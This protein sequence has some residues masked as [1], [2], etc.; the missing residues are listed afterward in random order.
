MLNL[1]KISFILQL[2]LIVSNQALAQKTINGYLALPKYFKNGVKDIDLQKIHKGNLKI[3]DLIIQYGQEPAI[4]QVYSDRSN[5]KLFHSPSLGSAK[6]MR[7]D[8]MEVLVVKEVSPNNFLHVYSQ[9]KNDKKDVDLGWVPA[10]NLILSPRSLLNSTS[11]PKKVMA[12][13]SVDEKLAEIANELSDSEITVFKFYKSPDL[14]TTNGEAQKFKIYYVIKEI[15]GKK[16]ISEFDKID[17]SQIENSGKIAGWI[18]DYQLTNWDYRVCLEISSRPEAVNSYQG[19]PI[20]IYPTIKQLET[21]SDGGY[22]NLNGSIAKWYTEE[23]RLDPYIM[24]MPILENLENNLKKVATIGSF[25]EKKI[26]PEEIAKILRQIVELQER[27]NNIN[28]VFV[29]D[30]TESM[31]DYYNSVAKSIKQI[32]DTKNRNNSNVKIKFGLI[33]YRDYKDG[34][35]TIEIEQITSDDSK[36]INKLINTECSSSPLDK[37]LEEAVFNGLVNGLPRVGMDPNQS[38]FVV[39][40]GDAG[41]HDPDPRNLTTKDV[42]NVLSKYNAS[43][44]TFQPSN[45]SHYSYSYFNTDIRKILVNSAEKYH[46]CTNC[47]RMVNEPNTVN[48]FKIQLKDNVGKPNQNENGYDWFG[49]FTYASGSQPMSTTILTDNIEKSTIEYIKKTEY[50]IKEL[51]GLLDGN[52]EI[53]GM[54]VGCEYWKRKYGIPCEKLKKIKNFSFIAYTSTRFYGKNTDCFD[55][56]VFLSEIELKDLSKFFSELSVDDLST[57]EKLDAFKNSITKMALKVIG[58]KSE[59]T[60]EQMTLNDIWMKVLGIPFDKNNKYLNLGN[61][62]IRNLN[63]DKKIM[64]RFLRNFEGSLSKFDTKY[65]IDCSYSLNGESFYWI[66]LSKFP[67]NE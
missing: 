44:L 45:G 54:E 35:R 53:K 23:K 20:P 8:Y 48:T 55:P 42:V 50:K 17:G 67:G 1:F 24:R 40:I 14:Q 28:I 25:K 3:S 36:I 41:N 16:L 43:F 63:K 52:G 19:K 57:S 15:P 7:M 47:V 22:N 66:P 56:V 27:L 4:W 58:E 37:D 34:N 31:K 32:I 39:L 12:L 38:N 49:K 13:F 10:E 6:S 61:T 62:Q 18:P 33:I 21:I 51:Q 5:N 30:G 26:D 64:D 46:E 59:E 11:L 2:I 9:F 60:I 65:F 29:I